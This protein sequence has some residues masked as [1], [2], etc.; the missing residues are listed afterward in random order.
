MR[1]IRGAS[2]PNASHFI[3]KVTV[4]NNN[5]VLYVVGRMVQNLRAP[6]PG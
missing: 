1:E 5:T 3:L 2:N 4:T 6:G